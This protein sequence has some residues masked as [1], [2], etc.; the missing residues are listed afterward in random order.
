MLVNGG[1]RPVRLRLIRYSCHCLSGKFQKETMEPGGRAEVEFTLTPNGKG[2]TLR[3]KAWLEFEWDG[4][5]EKVNAPQKVDSEGDSL[6]LTNQV[7]VE[8]QVLLLSRLRLGL[9]VATLDFN[10]DD[11]TASKSVQLTGSAHE[12]I[13]KEVKQP[14]DSRFRYELSDD[15]RSLAITA[16]YDRCSPK[17]QVMENWT[18]VTSDEKV[19]RLSLSLNLHVKHDFTVTPDGIELNSSGKF[20][21]NGCLLMK[22]TNPRQPVK[23]LRAV[24]EN[25]EGRLEIK[26]LPRGL[27]RIAYALEKMPESGKVA[28]L[29]I[30]TDSKL[31]EEVVIVVGQK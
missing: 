6:I 5:A 31:Q 4:K 17:R 11:A 29:R 19:P 9:D 25:A 12:A 28:A 8:V 10:D 2:G 3:Q 13:V 14:T 21:Q 1:D 22:P 24:W 15:R 30:Y 18:I 26:E 16:V 20:P 7:Q 23:V 27:T